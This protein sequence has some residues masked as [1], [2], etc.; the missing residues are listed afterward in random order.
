MRIAIAILF[1]TV[2]SAQPKSDQCCTTSKSIVDQLN[3]VTTKMH[4]SWEVFCYANSRFGNKR[5]FVGMAYTPGHASSHYIED[6]GR[7]GW[8]TV[9]ADYWTQEDAA[10][11]L[12][13]ILK[14]PPNR[15]PDH[16]PVT[17]KL[18]PRILHGGV[19]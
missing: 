11:A 6:G 5:A 1:A 4:L 3:A 9:K 14:L 18:C 16:A 15:Q 19:Q 12:L 17:P 13:E 2:L 10:K 8:L 7:P